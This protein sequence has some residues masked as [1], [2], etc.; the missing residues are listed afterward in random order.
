MIK[1]TPSL[2]IEPNHILWIQGDINY[3]TLRYLDGSTVTKCCTLKKFES[4][5]SDNYAF[6]RSHKGYLINLEFVERLS[7]DSKVAWISNEKLPIS[8]RKRREFKEHVQDLSI[9]LKD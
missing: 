4:A 7:L 8:R 9:P 2:L 3:S 6:F 5:L 1:I